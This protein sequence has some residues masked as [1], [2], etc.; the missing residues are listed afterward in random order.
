MSKQI[1]F[2]ELKCIVS[3]KKKKKYRPSVM[4]V[5]DFRMIVEEDAYRFVR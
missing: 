2:K 1:Y 3:R 4:C 5:T